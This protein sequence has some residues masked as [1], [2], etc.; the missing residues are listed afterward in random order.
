MQLF[1]ADRRI[2]QWLLKTSY[3]MLTYEVHPVFKAIM[4]DEGVDR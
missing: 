2:V 1:N 4:D 3:I